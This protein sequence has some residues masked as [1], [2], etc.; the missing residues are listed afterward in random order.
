MHLKITKC[1]DNYNYC[2]FDEHSYAEDR[3]FV[4]ML[5]DTELLDLAIQIIKEVCVDDNTN[6]MFQ[7][8]LRE[9]CETIYRNIMNEGIDEKIIGEYFCDEDF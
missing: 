6:K 2:E 3:G 7:D 4:E 8:K 9:N 5:H 1:K